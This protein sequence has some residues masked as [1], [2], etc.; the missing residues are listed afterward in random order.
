[1]NIIYNWITCEWGVNFTFII[2]TQNNF[3]GILDVHV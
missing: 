2:N 3:E 1:M